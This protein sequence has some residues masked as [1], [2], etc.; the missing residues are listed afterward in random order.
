MGERR[1]GLHNSDKGPFQGVTIHRG[2]VPSTSAP[3]DNWRPSGKGFSK[4]GVAMTRRAAFVY[5]EALSRHQ[6]RHDHPMRPIRLQ[7]T[8]ELLQA[9]GAFD[10]GVSQLVPPRAATD[11]ELARLHTEEY[12]EAVKCFSRGGSE[13]QR[14]RF[15][16]DDRG[17]NP[18]YGGMFE[19]AAMSTGSTLVA[20][21]MVASGQVDV[22]FN[23]SGGLHHAATGH[24][25]GFCVFND[26][27]LAIKALVA[28]GRRVAYVDIDAHHGDGV[29]DV[30]FDDDRVL[31]VSIHESGRYLFPGTG[32]ETEVGTGKGAG[33]SINIPLYPFTEDEVYLEAFEEVVP[34][35]LKAFAPDVLVT[36]LGIDSYYSDPLTHLQVTT[37]GFVATVEMLAS[38]GVPWLALGGGGYDLGAVAR[39][40]TLAYGVMLGTEWPDEI[41]ANFVNERFAAQHGLNR[42]RDAVRLDVPADVRRNARRFAEETVAVLRKEIFPVHGL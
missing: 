4:Q 34:P 14:A 8:F 5:D 9:Y 19:A 3:H 21:E 39:A 29:Q 7:H 38:M 22:A 24:A 33:Y 16:F 40:W 20:A 12:I 25:S 15:N 31:T 30:F 26:P 27:A 42:L 13:Y 23:I 18:T 37:R 1:A 28:A 35:L 36:Q 6:L 32:S 2:D 11:S 17:D 41:P 10:E